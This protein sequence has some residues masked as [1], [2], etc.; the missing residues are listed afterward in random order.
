[1]YQDTV[2]ITLNR[3]IKYKD[4]EDVAQESTRL[5]CSRPTVKQKKLTLHFVQV[6]MKAYMNMGKS[7]IATNPGLAAVSKSKEKAEDGQE[8]GQEDAPLKITSAEIML[9]LYTSD[10]DFYEFQE[11]FKELI[12]GSGYSELVKIDGSVALTSTH[13]DNLSIEDLEVFMG[14]YCETFLM[15]SVLKKLSTR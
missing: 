12:C 9:M 15:T 2:E 8:D 6:L 7:L 5:V 4:K 10:E 3:P 1:M 13:Y 11:E 14:V